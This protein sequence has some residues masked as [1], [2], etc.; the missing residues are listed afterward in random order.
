MRSGTYF[1]WIRKSSRMSYG[2]WSPKWLDAYESDEGFRRWLSGQVSEGK[3]SLQA[4]TKAASPVS[5]R[6]PGYSEM[7][8]PEGKGENS[9]DLWYSEYER[10]LKR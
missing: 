6:P 2:D 10:S 7:P 1:L 9:G 8:D 3:I 4:L 5:R